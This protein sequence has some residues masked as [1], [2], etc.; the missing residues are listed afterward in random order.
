MIDDYSLKT[1]DIPSK[2]ASLDSIRLTLHVDHK[3]MNLSLNNNISSSK[4][5]HSKF[6][7]ESTVSGEPL[8]GGSRRATYS[9][10]MFVWYN[11]RN[12]SQTDLLFLQIHPLKIFS[13]IIWITRSSGRKLLSCTLYHGHV[14]LIQ[15][16]KVQEDKLICSQDIP[17][18]SIF[19]TRLY[20]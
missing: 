14:L 20:Q 18:Q 16:F 3:D 8:D 4:N 12:I 7:R 9:M 11:V 15:D 13:K 2:L 19:E 10:D 17:T 5:T 1:L 6:F